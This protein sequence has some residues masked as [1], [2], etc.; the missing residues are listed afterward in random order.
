MNYWILGILITTIIIAGCT[1]NTSSIGSVP[2]IT[3]IGS[4]GNSQYSSPNYVIVNINEPVTVNNNLQIKINSL[5]I[6]SF[7]T[8]N[9]S[10]ETIY[11]TAE[12]GKQFYLFNVDFRNVGGTSL[13]VS[14]YSFQLLDEEG[15]TYD[16][17]YY[18]GDNQVVSKNMIPGS[19]MTGYIVF[20]IPTSVNLPKLVYDLSSTVEDNET[21]LVYWTFN[22]QDYTRAETVNATLRIGNTYPLSFVGYGSFGADFAITG[23]GNAPFEPKVNYSLSYL[24][25]DIITGE[26]K[27]L[28]SEIYPNSSSAGYVSDGRAM[29]N[30]GTYYIKV[31]LY[32]K[33]TNK[34]LDYDTAPVNITVLNN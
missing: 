9:L 5:V 23:T 6:S 14:G 7:Y 4:N 18:W 2:I 19:R 31:S 22:K 10:G 28:Y 24:G 3:N 32:D 33:S 16:S 15:Y 29:N 34:L 17:S 25:N 13:F 21:K 27:T 12:S 8:Y 1:L 30:S 11:E 20:E 26:D